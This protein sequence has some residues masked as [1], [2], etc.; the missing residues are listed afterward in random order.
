MGTVKKSSDHFKR[1]AHNKK[2]EATG[3]SLRGFFKGWLFCASF[4][5]LQISAIHQTFSLIHRQLRYLYVI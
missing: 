2:I 1:R 3:N 5:G 4:N